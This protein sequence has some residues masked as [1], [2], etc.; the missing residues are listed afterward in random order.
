MKKKY[1]FPIALAIPL[2]ISC[3]DS[4][5][6][7][8]E[9][10]RI[11]NY[12]DCLREEK[13]LKLSEIADTLEYLELKTPHEIVIS[14][15]AN[16]IPTSDFLLVQI[17]D[18]IYQ[19]T[20][21][22]EYLRKIGE[23]GQGPK[24]YLSIRGIDID[25]EKK[26]IIQADAQKIIYYDFDGN[27][28]RSTPIK[29]FF[30]NLVRADSVFWTTNL[31]LYVDKYQAC[32]LNA[33]GDT[34]A[35]V[36]N[37]NYGMTSQNTDGF[38][39]SSNL[40][41]REFSKYDGS[42][43]MK[44]RASRDTVYKISGTH[45]TPYLYFEMGKYRMPVEYEIWYSKQAYDRHAVDYWTVPRLEETDRYFL[46][47][48][49]RQ[50]EANDIKGLDDAEDYKYLAYDKE[51][52]KGFVLKNEHGIKIADDILSGPDF[53]PRWTS[54]EYYIDAIEWVDMA[55]KIEEKELVLKPALQKQFEKW[56]EDTNQIIVLARKK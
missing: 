39:I 26:E 11:I 2:F 8:K 25:P 51:T 38:Y 13:E 5:P 12:E 55:D 40:M 16:I 52:G 7:E 50:K 24:E 41:L 27:F 18:G 48:S 1:L 46:F 29:D 28:L 43:F 3:S 32:A 9:E 19:F 31:C 54:D 53:W 47:V 30:F 37:P 21:E 23:K 42:L 36:P 56:G 34:V 10:L 22:G 17:P 35:V 4:T 45:Y 6:S 15:I 33:T 20:K 14:R 44:T 49:A